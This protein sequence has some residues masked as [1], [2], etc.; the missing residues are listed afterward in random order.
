MSDDAKKKQ[1]KKHSAKIKALDGK[2]HLLGLGLDG[3]DGHTRIT[4]GKNFKLVGGSKDTH[5]AM[6]ETA[7]KVNEEL[8][9]RGKRLDDVNPQEFMDIMHK[10]KP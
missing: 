3:H 8:D 6:Q 7:I 9:R 1:P 2:A 5:E 10:S 4:S